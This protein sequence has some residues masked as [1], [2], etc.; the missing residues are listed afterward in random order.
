MLIY[1]RIFWIYFIIVLFFIIVGITTMQN[2]SPTIIVLWLIANLSLL[3]LMYYAISLKEYPDYNVINFVD[4]RILINC[5]FIIILILASL[6]IGN[7]TSTSSDVLGII[8]LI[9][10]LMLADITTRYHI[11]SLLFGI[12]FLTIWWGLVT[13]IMLNK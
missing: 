7:I 6:W 12:I 9:S 8:L 10:G 1:D 4:N 11:T 2:V 5:L 13:N 3:I